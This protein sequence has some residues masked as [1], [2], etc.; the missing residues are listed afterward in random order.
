MKIRKC[1]E[2]EEIVS[3]EGNEEEEQI[4]FGKL[5]TIELEGLK[6]LKSFCSSKNYEFKFPSLEGLIVRKCP[7]MHTFTE[8]DARAPKLE[9]TV[10][11]KEEGK[12][13]AKWQWEGDLNA[14]IQKGFNKVL[15]HLFMI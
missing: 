5:I 9:N 1:Y 12:E 7:M 2:L 6:K 4:V 13:E 8:G 15:I 10:T 3:D 14:T 11:A